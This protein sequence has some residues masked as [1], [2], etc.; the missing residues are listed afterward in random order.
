MHM[1]DRRV[2]LE[3]IKALK[4]N[5]AEAIECYQGI[6]QSFN[7]N[8]KLNMDVQ[9]LLVK[10]DS[11]SGEMDCSAGSKDVAMSSIDSANN[12]LDEVRARQLHVKKLEES[13]GELYQLFEDM[14]T[15]VELQNDLI[16]DITKSGDS[17]NADLESGSI[18]VSVAVQRSGWTWRR[19][20]C[21]ITTACVIIALTLSVIW[22]SIFN[23][24]KVVYR[25][26]IESSK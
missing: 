11:V 21:Y 1:S 22:L 10:P 24:P 17:I 5:F 7:K 20:L 6:Q 12:A 3:Q 9:I 23:K 16:F 14:E 26:I 18:Q 19:R 2:L 15:L 4:D 8:D 25:T 13:I